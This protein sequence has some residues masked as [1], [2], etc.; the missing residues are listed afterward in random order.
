MEIL[1]YLWIFVCMYFLF[2]LLRSIQWLIVGD[3]FK[4]YVFI[5]SLLCVIL[6]FS[7][8]YITYYLFIIIVAWEDNTDITAL[9]FLIAF[10]IIPI[11]YSIFK[12]RYLK[13]HAKLSDEYYYLW[14]F[15][16]YFLV[17]FFW[18]LAISLVSR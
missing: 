4:K 5:D 2:V 12:K 7:S 3:F 17:Y 14:E 15:V 16:L 6:P 13:N 1:S 8:Y 11:V 9:Y 18:G 10:I